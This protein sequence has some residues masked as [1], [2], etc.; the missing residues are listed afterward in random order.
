MAGVVLDA[1][2]VSAWCFSDEHTDYTRAVLHAVSSS[3]VDAVAPT[4]FAYEIRNSVLMALR[5]GRISKTDAEQ[6]LISLDE[7]GVRLIEA[8]SYDAL[9]SLAVAHGLTV[10]DAAYLGVAM[11]EGLPLASLDGA[12]VRAAQNAGAQLFLA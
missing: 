7:M 2:L 3:L 8:P 5:R 9:F 6:F 1:S 11:Q 4:L 12:L 10:Y